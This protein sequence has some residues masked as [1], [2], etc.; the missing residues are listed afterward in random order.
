MA[1]KPA[2]EAV[3][4][5]A[6]AEKKRTRKK[7]AETSMKA[8]AKKPKTEKKGKNFQAKPAEEKK[9]RNYNQ[10]PQE[11]WR[12]IRLDY[13]KGKM[14]LAKL[15][16][17]YNVPQSTIRKHASSERWK[18]KRNTL[19]TKVEQKTIERMADA[20][21]RELEK[22]AAIQDK[23]DDFLDAAVAAIGQVPLK[24]YDEMR[25]IESLTKAIQIAVQTK[26]DL[27]NIPNEADRAKIESLR[28]KARLDRQR[29]EDEKAEKAKLAQAVADTMIRVVIEGEGGA[30]DE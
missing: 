12:K 22:L 2:K 11:Q 30:L 16:E 26:R 3:E 21:A 25:G 10:L 4:L 13:V 24:K 23:V 19:D 5:A 18:K 1:K 6:P 17:K 28:E 20:R 9:K 29:Y 15:A 7:P 14:T 8:P 27:Y